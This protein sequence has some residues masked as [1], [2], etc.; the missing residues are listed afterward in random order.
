[1]SKKLDLVSLELFASVCEAKSLARAAELQNIAASA[2]S[3]RISQLEYVTGV[4]LLVRSRS[5]VVPT[6]AGQTLLEHVRNV[7]YNLE[8]IERDITNKPQG[9]SGHIR[10]FASASAMTVFLPQSV[11]A[12]LSNPRYKDIDI[13]IDEMVSHE[14]VEGVRD[15]RAMLGVC[16]D[17]AD[18]KG[19][20]VIPYKRDH[21]CAMVPRG[22]PLAGRAALRFAD[23]LDYPHAGLRPTSAVTAMLRRESLKLG[24]PVK[25]RVLVSSFQAVY[26]VVNAGI[27]ISIIPEE[28]ARPLIQNGNVELI[29]LL[30][31]WADRGFNICCRSRRHLSKAAELLVSHMTGETAGT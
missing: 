4:Q 13:D 25:F 20:E 28:I 15:G 23:T 16:W 26:G 30:D 10:I 6:A 22:H 3:K 8:L 27:A 2:I 21:L 14:V 19:L 17:M 9:A 29:P 12:F 18:M 1:M 24:Q 31:S 11:S 5:G 7:L